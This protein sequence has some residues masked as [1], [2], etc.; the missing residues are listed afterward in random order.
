MWIVYEKIKIKSTPSTIWHYWSDVENWKK[1][2][3]DIQW[4]S[5][6]GPFEVGTTGQL[7]PQKGP[8]A[9]F[10]ITEL[11]SHKKFIDQSKLPFTSL[12]FIHEI[13]EETSDF[14]TVTHGIQFTGLLSPL[15]SKLI[16]K[17][18]AKGLPVSLQKLKE[19]AENNP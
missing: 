3:P 12:T 4:S 15:F 13:E 10:I 7:K 19:L 9:S 2:D 5:I 11:I 18:L 6:N 8:K 1:W 17:S 14:V 16:G